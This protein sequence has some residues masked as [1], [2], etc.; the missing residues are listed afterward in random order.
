[1]DE[2]EA[3]IERTLARMTPA[4]KAGLLLL[5]SVPGPSLDRDTGA[6]LRDTG[7]S[8]AVLF[9]PNV[10]SSAQLRALT[11]AIEGA[12]GRE[13]FPA[14]IASDEEGGRVQRL[15]DL[16]PPFPGAMAVAA[17]GDLALAE[18]VGRAIGERSRAHGLNVVFA[19]VADVN[20]DPDNPVIGPRSYG[21]NP[22]AV[23]AFVAAA[24]RGLAAAGVA[25]TA[26]HFPGHGDTR[27]DSHV[28]LPTIAHGLDRLRATELV[29]FRAA[30]AAG[31]PLVMTAHIRFPAL[32]GSGDPATL[33]APILGGL[34]RGELGFDGVIISDAMNMAAIRDHYG[35]AEGCVRSIIAGADLVEPLMRE[36]EVAAALAAAAASGRLPMGRLDDAARRVLRLRRGLAAGATAGDADAT[37]E[38]HAALVRRVARAGVT[39]LDGPAGVPH[40]EEMRFRRDAAMGVIE[41]TLDYGSR[42]EAGGAGGV[43]S[44]PL[45]A[46][47]R[48]RFPAARGMTLDGMLPPTAERERAAALVRGCDALVIGTRDAHLHAVQAAA[49]DALLRLHASGGAGRPT[50]VVSLRAPYDLAGL[51]GVARVAAYGDEPDALAAAA[52]ICAR[53]GGDE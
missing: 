1:M 20:S 40:G 10:A 13:G 43:A 9:A 34:L 42:A 52:A 15:R 23:A 26:K 53:M 31:V 5:A 14:L 4:E 21:E 22:Q 41:F 19:P 29:P 28:A 17:T 30:I 24:V 38:A 25:A 12:C 18:A 32:D 16:G 8:G 27:L 11:A 36:R 6:M 46:A 50:A 47:F 35:V 37:Q 3:A 48:E 2:T 49:R 44:S 45:L 39:L 33:S 7:A 51:A